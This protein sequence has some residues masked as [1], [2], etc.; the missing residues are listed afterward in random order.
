MFLRGPRCG[1]SNDIIRTRRVNLTR[2]GR[3]GRGEQLD[4]RLD[5]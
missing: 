3:T 5:L 2:L 1:D 4:K